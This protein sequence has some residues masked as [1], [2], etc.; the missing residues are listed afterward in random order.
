LLDDVGRSARKAID[1]A[2]EQMH[3]WLSGVR[4]AGRFPSP[5]EREVL[6]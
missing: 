1:A 2:A 5:L 6:G 3:A 4:V